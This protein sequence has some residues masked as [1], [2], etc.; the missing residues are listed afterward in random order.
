MKKSL[1]MLGALSGLAIGGAAFVASR[2]N[3]AENV[4]AA[5][6][7]RLF[8][9]LSNC[10][11]SNDWTSASAVTF[12]RVFTAPAA[13]FYPV[14][15]YATGGFYYVDAD[16]SSGCQFVRV[17]PNE[18]NGSGLPKVDSSG[19]GGSIWSYSSNRESDTYVCTIKN[20]GQGGD[21]T[22]NGNGHGEI[23]EIADT[24]PSADTK[25]VWVNPKDS[26]NDSGARAGLRVFVGA[27]K[28]KNYLLGGSAQCEIVD[29]N[30]LFYIDIPRAADCQLVRIH[31]KF[32]YI[33]TY[34]G[35]FSDQLTYTTSK[36]VYSTRADAAYSIAN[37]SNPTIAYAK[38]VLDGYQTC[39]D[40]NGNGYSEIANIKANIIDHLSPADQATLRAASFGDYT[41]G[42]KIDNMTKMANGTY[43]AF[44]VTSPISNDGNEAM[45]AVVGAS[46]ALLASAGF[47]F[48]RRKKA[49]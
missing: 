42:E 43:R 36:V 29:G 41:Y 38:L 10:S 48:I 15:E 30:Y 18:L 11:G 16:I 17:N 32:N 33:W 31:P 2:T 23:Y 25:R 12:L 5:G 40:N 13:T 8:L 20:Y 46:G 37:E 24:E 14:T 3:A 47:I 26:F 49:F 1:I 22:W 44:T 34:G 39:S 45:I 21:T 28:P 35:N 4:K 19:E 27:S 6:E 7:T 9:D